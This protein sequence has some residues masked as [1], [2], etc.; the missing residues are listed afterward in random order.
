MT[1]VTAVNDDVWLQSGT[2]VSDCSV[3]MCDSL[4]VCV[5]GVAQHKGQVDIPCVVLTMFFVLC[6]LQTGYSGF[7]VSSWPGGSTLK[8]VR[9]SQNNLPRQPLAQARKYLSYRKARPDLK[10]HGLGSQGSSARHV[11]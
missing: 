11:D 10:S 7:R 8:V 6:T 3:R 9:P 1:V 4:S 5:G 2:T